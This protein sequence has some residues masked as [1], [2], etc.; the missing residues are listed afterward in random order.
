MLP[1]KAKITAL[2]WSGRSRPKLSQDW[3]RLACQ[4]LSCV[5]TSTPTS[6]PTMPQM[7][8]ASRN[9]RTTLSLNSRVILADD[10]DRRKRGDDGVGVEARAS[11]APAEAA[12]TG[13]AAAIVTAA[14]SFAEA[15]ED[16]AVQSRIA[17]R[18]RERKAGV[19]LRERQ[20]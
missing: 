18:L 6:M 13:R 14:S 4:K 1:T 12:R 3:P 20:Q 5:A 8:V 9:W 15:T 7:R 2:V 10:I 16:M 11:G 19:F 17:G